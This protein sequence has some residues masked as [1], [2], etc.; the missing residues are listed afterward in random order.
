MQNIDNISPIQR[1]GQYA[2][3]NL[4]WFVEQIFYKDGKPLK[5]FPFQQV[6]LDALWHKKFVML[7]I[8]RGGSKT[9]MLAIYAVLRCLLNQGSKI[10]VTGAGFRQAKH[11]FRY[12]EELYYASPILQEAIGHQGGVK[13]GADTVSIKIGNSTIRGIPLADGK[14]VRGERASHLLADE[15]GSISPIVFDHAIAPFTAAGQDPV[16]KNMLINFIKTL[17]RIGVEQEFIDAVQILRG[18]GNQIVYSGSATHIGNHFGNRYTVFRNIIASGGDQ[19]K[20]GA[21]IKLKNELTY[22]HPSEIDADDLE[23]LAN[24]WQHHV[25]IQMPYTALPPGMME[26]DII[27]SEK[28]SLPAHRFKEEYMAEFTSDT[29]GFIKRSWIEAATPKDKQIYPELYGDPKATYVMG[30]DPARNND[31]VGIV[32]LKITST[33][34]ELIYCNAWNRTEFSI[35]AKKIQEIAKRF[36]IVRIAMDKGGGGDSIREWLCKKSEDIED[37]DLL[38]V[39]PDQ[40]EKEI[41]DVMAMSAPGKKIIE[42]VNFSPNWI[43]LAAHAVEA[44]IQQCNMLF[45]HS[46]DEEQS[47]RQYMIHYNIS[48]ITDAIKDKIQEELWGIDAWQAEHEDKSVRLGIVQHITECLNEMCA[49]VRFVIPGSLVEKFDLPK[50]SDQPEGLDMRR[51]DR[52]SALMLA[53][54]A[55][56]VYL[57]SGH[58]PKIL[59]GISS[60]KNRGYTKNLS[61]RKGSTAW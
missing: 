38:W 37:S 28:A 3:L 52:W 15:F 21:A 4:A 13:W 35:S 58:K 45:P 23:S 20:L 60:Q 44:D 46:G 50:L 57:G 61:K 59:P 10:I 8:T 26:E 30:I 7:I 12:I 5:L 49:I 14:R 34:K 16:T 17:E 48:K 51:R 33:Q 36:N 53:N 2:L 55:A 6:I 19:E 18:T 42:M 9:W 22:G 54:Y 31:N 39:V 56:K 43:S 41:G 47:Y 11:V 1:I 32:I 40:M 25:V 29:D 24:T 27:R